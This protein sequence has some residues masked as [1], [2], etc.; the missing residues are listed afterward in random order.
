[1]TGPAIADM[2]SSGSANT[3]G[4]MPTR[5]ARCTA[6]A[7]SVVRS[8]RRPSKRHAGQSACLGGS[9]RRGSYPVVRGHRAPQN[10]RSALVT[11]EGPCRAMVT[12]HLDD[13]VGSDDPACRLASL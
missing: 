1:M 6:I 10:R 4:Q 5:T 12:T 9:W 7:A 11:L 13:V 8:D 2:I 3:L